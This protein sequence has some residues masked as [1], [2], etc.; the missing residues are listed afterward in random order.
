LKVGLQIGFGG[1]NLQASTGVA[2]RISKIVN[3]SVVSRTLRSTF[4]CR[5]CLGAATCETKIF[6]RIKCKFFIYFL[7]HTSI[8]YET[9]YLEN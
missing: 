4:F 6:S 2:L 9:I 1:F 5:F 8:C 7:I 3:V